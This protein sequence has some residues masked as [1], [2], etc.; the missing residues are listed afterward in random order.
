MKKS[1]FIIAITLL[2]FVSF[3]QST[4]PRF[5][6]GPND[7]NTGRVLTYRYFDKVDAVGNDTLKIQP[8]AWSTTLRFVLTDSLG[9]DANNLTQ[10]YAGDNISIIATGASGTKVTFKGANWQTAG[11]ATLSSGGTAVISLVF[12]G[13][14]WVEVSR[15]VQ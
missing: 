4:T 13:T 5:G 3:S 8:R 2:S 7:D 11:T 1:T 12:S 14:K 15:A 9:I 10:S 6:T